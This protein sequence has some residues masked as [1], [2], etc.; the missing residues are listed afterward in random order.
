MPMDR[1]RH[2]LEAVKAGE[3][4][5][6]EALEKVTEVHDM[7]F[8]QLD[9]NREKRTGFPEVIYGKG[10][11][12][13]QL[14]AIFE[15]LRERQSIVMATRVTAEQAQLV[16]ERFS[17]V[18]F[19]EEAS[20]LIWSQY[21]LQPSRPG[22]IAVV[23]AGTSDWPVAQEAVWTARCFGSEVRL[24][25]DVGVAGIHRLFHRLEEIRG[26]SVIICVAGMEG[27]LA[28]VLAG[29]VEKPVIAV[30]T[31]VG[32]GANFGGL[33]ALL[34]MLNSCANGVAVVNIDNGFGAGYLAGMIHRQTA[35][36][37]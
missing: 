18:Q 22:Y 8:A 19:I 20:M 7:G 37:G 32:Y 35:H 36:E 13:Q 9:L 24:I 28:S 6:E 3:L 5:V 4:S 31:S 27:A 14:S 30:P 10:K 23:A 33:A 25:A 16:L 26:A 17:D 11:T 12:P 15:R 34:T 2:L 21:P 29:L 1:L